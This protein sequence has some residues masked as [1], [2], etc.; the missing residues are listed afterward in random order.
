MEDANFEQELKDRCEFRKR[1]M[2]D[3]ESENKETE[4]RSGA[5]IQ[6]IRLLVDNPDLILLIC[7]IVFFTFSGYLFCR[8]YLGLTHA[9]IKTAT[10]EVF[11]LIGFAISGMISTAAKL[12]VKQGAISQSLSGYVES[13]MHKARD[14]YG[15]SLPGK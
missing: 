2:D 10:E 4:R 7:I 5:L 1:S 9:E 8:I 11:W 13:K 6:T 12:A 3:Q 15:R 14:T